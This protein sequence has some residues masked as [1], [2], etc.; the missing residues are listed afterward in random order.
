MPVYLQLFE[1]QQTVP[2]NCCRLVK[3]DEY[4][5]TLER[6]F[7]GEEETPM[8]KLLGGIK[9]TYNFDLLLETKRLDQQF[10]EYKPGGKYVLK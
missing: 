3:Y 6:S 1:L 7:E 2:L 5:D 4:Q 8:G 10:Q 9:Q